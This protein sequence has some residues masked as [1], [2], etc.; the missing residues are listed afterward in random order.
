MATQ[1]GNDRGIGSAM[2]A[3]PDLVR[4]EQT[5]GLLKVVMKQLG[6]TRGIPIVFGAVSGSRLKMN[7]IV[8]CFFLSMWNTLG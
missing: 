6:L 3:V 5:R 7:D 4:M 2:R 8:P 1:M